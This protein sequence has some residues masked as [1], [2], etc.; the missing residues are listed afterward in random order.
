MPLFPAA[1]NA[2]ASSLLLNV[3]QSVAER[4]PVIEVVAVGIR[5]WVPLQVSEVPVFATESVT[6]PVALLT[7]ETPVT[8]PVILPFNFWIAERMVSDAVMVPAPEVYPVRVEAIARAFVKYRFDPSGRSDV[9]AD[10]ET[11]PEDAFKIPESVP[12]VR[13]VVLVLV[14]KSVAKRVPDE[15][16]V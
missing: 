14:V 2:L 12:T 13:L 1:T 6:A 11:T 15:P 10:P 16:R 9:V 8:S 7:D 5:S 4:S 3:F